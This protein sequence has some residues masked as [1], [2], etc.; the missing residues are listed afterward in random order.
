MATTTPD[1]IYSPDAGQQYALTQDLLAMADSVQNALNNR[2]TVLRGNGAPTLNAPDNATYLDTSSGLL[3]GRKSGDWYRSGVGVWN[4]DG[5]GVS[6]GSIITPGGTGVVGLAT[7]GVSLAPG[8]ILDVR[9]S[10]FLV[11]NTTTTF[12]GNIEILR[13]ASVIKSRRWHSHGS[14]LQAWVPFNFSYAA[15]SAISATEQFTIRVTNDATSAG[16]VT[17]WDS[18]WSFLASWWGR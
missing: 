9:G 11:N 8:T 12:A 10:V 6:G 3:Y 5:S 4:L 14:P 17:A 18:Q 7:T 15:P 16:G 13:G 2:L 1:N